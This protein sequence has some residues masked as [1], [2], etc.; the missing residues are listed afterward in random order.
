MTDIESYRYDFEIVRLTAEQV[1]RDF[2]TYGIEINFSGNELTAWDEMKKQLNPVL[3]NLFKNNRQAFQ[4]LMYRID[5]S[6]K[7]LK[8]IL[9]V[10][11]EEFGDKITEAVIRREFKKVLIRKF[12]SE[13]NPDS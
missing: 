8:E 13:N 5:I 4:S 3:S 12:Y 1:I 7:Q 11:K 6:E 10:G 9:V 2:G